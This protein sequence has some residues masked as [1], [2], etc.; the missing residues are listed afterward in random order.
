MSDEKYPGN[1]NWPPEGF[2][3][4]GDYAF[5]PPFVPTE[6]QISQAEDF[7]FTN[8]AFEELNEDQRRINIIRLARAAATS[9]MLGPE[10]G[11]KEQSFVVLS[12]GVTQLTTTRH[13]GTPIFSYKLVNLQDMP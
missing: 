1:N 3:A 2:V 12:G 7:I 5:E 4:V 9:F 6:D 8:P 10:E 13:E 11:D